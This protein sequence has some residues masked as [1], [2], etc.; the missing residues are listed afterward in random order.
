MAKLAELHD[1]MNQI[2]DMSTSM[3]MCFAKSIGDGRLLLKIR[4][5]QS[6]KAA[7]QEVF[8]WMDA[9]LEA[10]QAESKDVAPAGPL[11][12]ALGRKERLAEAE[13]TMG[14]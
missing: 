2:K 5:R 14:E 12:R 9:S 3:Q 10:S 8:D 7:W 13:V 6:A 11:A 1:Q 4:Q